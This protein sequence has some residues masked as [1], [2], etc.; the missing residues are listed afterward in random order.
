M[1]IAFCGGL[2]L[3]LGGWHTRKEFANA[4]YKIEESCLRNFENL[5]HSVET[6][7]EAKLLHRN[8]YKTKINRNQQDIEIKMIY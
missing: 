1:G 8:Y 5:L 2:L 6:N 3:K 4:I 7:L